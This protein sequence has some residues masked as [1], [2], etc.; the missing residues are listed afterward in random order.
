MAKKTCQMIPRVIDEDRYRI[1][2]AGP[3][4]APTKE[5]MMANIHQADE[6]GKALLLAGHYPFIPHTQSQYWWDDPRPEFKSYDLIVKDFD[7]MGWL[8]VCDAVF[9][10]KNWRKSKGTR[11]EHRA[12]RKM[13]KK[14]FFK[15]S[16]VPNVRKP[17]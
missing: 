6:V 4:S 3:I 16:Q 7:I 5:Q 15:L 9:F 1:Y 8:S 12:A 14:C 10:C 13:G 17:E 2:V 11:M